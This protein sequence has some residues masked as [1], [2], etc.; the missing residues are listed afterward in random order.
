M[1]II[2]VAYATTFKMYYEALGIITHVEVQQNW[3]KRNPEKIKE[4]DKIFNLNKKAK[5]W[6]RI[7]NWL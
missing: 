6:E 3:S 7:Y 4:I 1:T 5:K 2:T